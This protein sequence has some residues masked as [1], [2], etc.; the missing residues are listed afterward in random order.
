MPHE[1]YGLDYDPEREVLVTSGG[2]EAL[3]AAILGLVGPGDEIVLI[4]P[5][6]RF[7]SPDGRSG[8]RGGEDR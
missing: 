3:A 8:R 4:E 6:L 5:H 7:L 2:T 1:F